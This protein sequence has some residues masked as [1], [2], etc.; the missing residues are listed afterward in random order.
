VTWHRMHLTGRQKRHWTLL[1][2]LA[3]PALAATAVF[4]S[5]AG[6]TPSRVGDRP[7]SALNPARTPRE[8]ASVVGL[9]RSLA[10]AEPAV[11]QRIVEQFMATARAAGTPLPTRGGATFVYA[12]QP[13]EKEV[14][15]VGELTGWNSQKGLPMIRIAGTDLFSLTV[16]LPRAARIEYQLR[17]GGRGILDPWARGSNDNGVGGRNSNF[18]MP[19][20]RDRSLAAIDPEVTRVAVDEFTLSDGRRCGVYR[21]PGY[22]ASGAA[23]YPALYLHDGSDYRKRARVTEIADSLIARRRIR[24]LLIVMVDPVQRFEEYSRGESYVRLMLEELVPRIDRDYRTDARP[25]GRAVGGASMGA[26]SPRGWRWSTRR[27]SVGRCAK[28]APTRSATGTCCASPRG[29]PA[30]TCASG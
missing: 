5:P 18:A 9:R 8:A 22:D 11:R 16:S 28:A 30:A 1:F 25:Q 2:P 12:A 3:L 4:L 6:S 29:G 23:R 7:V 26:S 15:L 21:P 13:G 19:G 27:C 10:D 14:Q 17:V 20:D 24:P